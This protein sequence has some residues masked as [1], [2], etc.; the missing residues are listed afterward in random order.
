MQNVFIDEKLKRYIVP[1]E[2]RDNSKADGKTFTHGTRIKI[3]K[4]IKFLR[5]FTA[6]ASLSGESSSIDIDMGGAFIKEVDGKLELTPIS[7][8]N[9]SEKFAVHSG[10]I[11]TCKKYKKPEDTITAEFIDV[12]Y[13]KV[14]E[15]GYK[16]FI[17]AEFIF[18]SLHNENV[19]NK[20]QI[21]SGITLLN[22]RRTSTEQAINLNN[23]LFRM[24][25][26]GEYSSHTSFAIDLE[27]DEIVILD[28]YSKEKSGIN[29]N[30]MANKLNVYKK[31]LFNAFETKEN[32][33]NLLSMYCEANSINI[34]D[35]MEEAEIICS[36]EDI[37]VK[38]GQQL[39]NVSNNLEKIVSLLNN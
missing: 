25:L 16:Y 10:D 39:F 23:Y 31:Q 26:S 32:M 13:N 17:T 37:D 20:M 22:E 29:I 11:R 4:D 8:Y 7:Y 34:V 33:Y 21:W 28:Q 6:W 2:M 3:E 30:N 12:N 14:K 38:E 1:M 27:T 24:K 18:S 5:V 9:Q 15:A 35:S 19:F 36:Y